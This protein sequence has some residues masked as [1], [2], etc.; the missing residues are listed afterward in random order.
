VDVDRYQKGLG[1]DEAEQTLALVAS[2]GQ[3][4]AEFC[5]LA[6]HLPVG[7]QSTTN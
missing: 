5:Q 4:D 1:K 7:I 3:D 6:K 2:V